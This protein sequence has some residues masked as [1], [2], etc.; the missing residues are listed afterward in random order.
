MKEFLNIGQVQLSK[1]GTKQIKLG[2]GVQEGTKS[3]EL[4]TA[5]IEILGTEYISLN[6]LQDKFDKFVASG[7][8]T[9]EVADA[10]LAKIPEFVLGEATVVIET[11]G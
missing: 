11:E 6:G 10:K 2:Q 3:A 7:N 9:R 4:A 1:K 8:M 5:L